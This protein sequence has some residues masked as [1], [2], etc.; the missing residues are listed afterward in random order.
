M[1][2]LPGEILAGL[3]LLGGISPL[4]HPF[5]HEVMK[6]L[7]HGCYNMLEH[8]WHDFHACM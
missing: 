2:Y 3:S 4:Y 1:K 8:H 7:T 5:L 6:Y